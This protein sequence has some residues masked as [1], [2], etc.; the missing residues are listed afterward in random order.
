ML[1][2][3]GG[4]TMGY[5]LAGYDV[6]GCCE[7]DP[8]M[9]AVY[10]SNHHPKYSYNEPI[11]EFKKGTF[12]DEL[13]NLDI[14]DGSPPCS[15]FSMIGAREDHWGKEKKFK[16]GQAMQVLDTLFFDFI[17]VVKELQPKVVIA[18]NVKGLM[19][20]NAISYVR[21]IYQG[22]ED[23]GYYCQHFLCNAKDMGVPQSRER[24]FFVCLRKDLAE[25]FLYQKDLFSMVPKIDLVFSEPTITV[26]EFADLKGDEIKGESTRNLWEHRKNGDG[27]MD[28]ACKRLYGR[29]SYFG[30]RY[31]YLDKPSPTLTAHKDSVIHFDAPRFTSVYEACNISTFPHDYDFGKEQPW[32]I[33]GMSVPPVMMA[34][35]AS[36]VYEQWLSKI[37]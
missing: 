19:L 28:D 2:M 18:E 32:Y 27:G 16:E 3:W 9:M 30:Q 36:R 6:V 33:M 14:L 20:G 24:V 29:Q 4:S 15:S 1:F 7:I 21:K 25:P 8:R 10:V 5:K 22:F 13:Y 37:K 23:A 26:G 17:E 12:P 11:Q 35:V 34:Q 31:C